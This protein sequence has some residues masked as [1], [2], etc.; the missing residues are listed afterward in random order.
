GG[1]RPD[2]PQEE[3]GSAGSDPAGY[4][5][6]GPH[7]GERDL[8]TDDMI[9]EIKGAGTRRDQA[10]Q[11]LI[12]LETRGSLA[13]HLFL[14]CLKDTG[15]RD[16]ADLLQTAAANQFCYQIQYPP[17]PVKPSTP[18][19]NAKPVLC[20][21]RSFVYETDVSY[22]SYPM[23]TT[24]AA[25]CFI[26]NNMEFDE[27]TGLSFRTGSDIDRDKMESR[28]RSFHFDVTVKNNLTGQA[29]H[30]ELQALAALDHSLSDCCLVVILSHGCETRHSKFPGGVFG[31]DGKQ[32]PVE[33]IVGYFDGAKCPGLRGKPKIFIIQ[34]CGGEQ[35]DRGCEVD[36][37]PISTSLQSD[38]TP[39]SSARDDDEVD[40]VS[41]IP[42]HGDILVSY[43]TYPG[44][45][46]WR[47]KHTGSWYIE[48]L[49]KVLEQ[50][51]ATEDLQSLLVKV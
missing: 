4:R 49:D 39:G 18:C 2:N 30:N 5:S 12:D 33:R 50:H 8:H 51:A 24:P 14:Q 42:T 3:P 6:V 31:T 46:S 26:I 23:T 45:V 36:S 1:E 29:I 32:I 27:C 34:A 38:A 11:L 20:M 28:M 10:R 13:F 40:A 19:C 9:E 25:P 44:Y 7:G 43:S 41:C 47:D 48:V 35:R 16:T 17:Y 22:C 15:Q 21:N 37:S